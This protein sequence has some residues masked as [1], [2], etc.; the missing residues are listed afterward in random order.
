MKIYD[1]EELLNKMTYIPEQEP[2]SSNFASAGY[3]SNLFLVNSQSFLFLFTIQIS[4]MIP[5]LLLQL[6][7][8]CS[9]MASHWGKRLS[10]LLFWNGTIRLFAEAYIEFCLFSML[11]L[12]EVNWPQYPGL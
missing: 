5:W 11:N 12:N 10:S 9:K 8:K 6:L 3:D 7:G 1:T 2:L 4:L